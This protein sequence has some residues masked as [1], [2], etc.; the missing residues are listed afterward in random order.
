MQE[1]S[2]GV[3]SGMQRTL[4]RRLGHLRRLGVYGGILFLFIITA[5][6]QPALLRPEQLL[7]ITKLAS[8]L[9]IAALG[10]TFVT[11][12]RGFDISQGGIITL[13]IV[14]S[15]TI[16]DGN[17]HNIAAGVAACLVMGCV[18]GIA[19]GLFVTVFRIPSIIATLGSF[20]VTSGGA[21]IYSGGVPRGSIPAAFQIVGR[22]YVGPLPLST[23]IWLG[24]TL[25]AALYLHRTVAGRAMFARGANE[26]AAHQSGISIFFYGLLPY[27]LS[28]LAA[29]CA[30][31]VFAAYMGL[32]DLQ[33]SSLYMLGPIAAA[34]VGGTSLAGGEGTMLG[35][36]AGAFFL[37]FLSA[38]I[39]SF[40]LPEGVRMI[41]TGLII[42]SA[43]YFSHKENG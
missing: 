16:M 15:N 23:L 43:I 22:G 19:N 32:P 21:V 26:T 35:T 25:I 30:G 11:V 14:L 39:I 33:V 18:V 8:V 13:T 20:A 31:L 7:S 40:D 27:V 4:G 5:V 24:L 38:L 6:L 29:C 37:T 9:G 28:S 12:S 1:A 41:I 3:V 17:T 36:S 42:V 2:I 34:V 10:Q